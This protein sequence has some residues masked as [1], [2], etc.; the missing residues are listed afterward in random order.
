MTYQTTKKADEDIIGLYVRG[1]VEFGL[2]QTESYVDGLFS[3]F[4][5]LSDNPYMARERSEL[6]PPARLHPYGAHMIVYV[7]QDS[8]ILVVRVLHGRQDWQSLLS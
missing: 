8:G 7:L 1:A 3:I 6:K 5:L 2:A 4:E